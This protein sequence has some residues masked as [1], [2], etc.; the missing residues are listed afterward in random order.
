MLFLC[1]PQADYRP[2][3]AQIDC[4]TAGGIL[5]VRLPPHLTQIKEPIHLAK[6]V[7]LRMIGP[8][9]VVRLQC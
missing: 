2:I 5:Y 6:N 8:H 7:I 4:L 9:R 1:E 3:V